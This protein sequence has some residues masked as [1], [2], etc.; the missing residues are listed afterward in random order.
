M[1][2]TFLLSIV[3]LFCICIYAQNRSE[4]EAE[5][6]ARQFLLSESTSRHAMSSD[7][8]SVQVVLTL[9]HRAKATDGSS[10]YY[11]Y[12]REGG[13][14]VIVSGDVRLPAVLG[15]S[16]NGNFKVD[17]IPANM[18]LWLNNYAK[19]Y[20]YLQKV[21][22]AKVVAKASV[23][24]TKILP[25][26]PCTWGQG[27]P[28]N[29]MCP[30]IAGE[31]A[32]T[33]CVATAMAQVMYYHQ[34]PKTVDGVGNLEAFGKTVISWDS[35]KDCFAPSAKPYSQNAVATLMKLCGYAVQMDYGVDASSADFLL[36]KDALVDYFDYDAAT[37]KQVWKS[38]YSSQAWKQLI[39]DEIKNHR[40]VIYSG[41]PYAGDG[42]A[43]V[44]DGYDKNDYFHVNWG[45]SGIDD[46]YFLLNSLLDYNNNQI[47]VVGIKGK[48][49]E[50]EHNYSYATLNN[51]TLTFQCDNKREERNGVLFTTIT[52]QP[53][54]N[55]VTEIKSVKFDE[56]F[57]KSKLIPFALGDWFAN[58]INL[59]QVD[60]T[61]FNSS[62]VENMSS[63]FFNCQ[64]LT[65]VNFENFDTSNV[66]DMSNMF[67]DCINLKE[68]NLSNF[69]TP[70]LKRMWSMFCGCE[71]LKTLDLSSFN[72][73]Q[74]TEMDCLFDGCTNLTSLN[75]S[76][77]NTSN[78]TSM[79]YIFR[80][81]KSLEALDLSSFVTSNIKNMNLMF[82]NC[83][84]LKT[85][86]V[87]NF[88]TS[89]VTDMRYMFYNC[90]NLT[91]LDLSNFNTSN[92]TNMSWMFYNC[93][94]LTTLDVSS[95]N[96]L[97][98]TDMSYMFDNCVSL[99]ALDVSNFDTSNV[100][101]M[102]TMF[103]GCQELTSLDVSN[104]NTSKVT[105]MNYMFDC[106]SG[107][108]SLDV[109]NFDTSNVTDMSHM[110][111]WCQVPILDVSNFNTSKV[112][113]MNSM[114]GRCNLI[115]TLDLSNFD[116]SHV[117]N[118]SKMFYRTPV[119]TIYCAEGADW[120]GIPVS[121][122]AFFGCAFLKGKSANRTTVYS[123]SATDGRLARACTDTQD[124]YFTIKNAQTGIE[125]TENVLHPSDASRRFYTLGGQSLNKCQ[126]GV[127][128]VKM[129]DGTNKKIIVE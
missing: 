62:E 127:V 99:T 45:W 66:T 49:A 97:K 60:F 107:L 30:E 29:K 96:T 128:V 55:Y 123:S 70:R 125:K 120:S 26:L 36:I 5:D 51:G 57:Q 24:G 65:S 7:S 37:I 103:R 23:T 17:N 11:V 91:S 46:G 58:C 21:P 81:C 9:A 52:A 53:F 95:F 19:E 4:Y 129:S 86:D 76:S 10:C 101:D 32:L 44:I 83:E 84:K 63:T 15:Y 25:L 116:I 35:M 124:G 73:S 43:F 68:L 56:S 104:F 47:A 79:D 78:V 6:I 106:C 100:T 67:V 115:E 27:W 39:Y 117:T 50:V 14:F 41:E 112:T 64:N 105:D 20:E 54:V 102:N 59:E 119:E 69:R 121:D 89:N 110:F 1:K 72:T 22:D 126:K 40:P 33:G 87:S 94:N 31:R 90:Q 113:N 77:F 61:N 114:F 8:K 28:F 2:K 16:N 38:A 34:W 75:L 111:Y 18:Q 48:G 93:I 42:H 13:G 3:M 88:S 108:K 118:I 85:L 98:V 109:S 80:N 92:V 82:M 71:S 12:N 122:E 74:V